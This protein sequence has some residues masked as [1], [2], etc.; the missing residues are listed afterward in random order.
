MQV[1][2]CVLVAILASLAS[3][4][5]AAI[6][7]VS[8]SWLDWQFADKNFHLSVDFDASKYN[9]ENLLEK[10]FEVESITFDF[11]RLGEF[12]KPFRLVGD[13][14][15][16]QFSVRYLPSRGELIELRGSFDKNVVEPNGVVAGAFSFYMLSSG[17]FGNTGH[18]AE[19]NVY[20]AFF[21][22]EDVIG[23]RAAYIQLPISA[24]MLTP[25]PESNIFTLLVGGLLIFRLKRKTWCKRIALTGETEG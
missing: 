1:A 19:L 5:N 15:T 16:S 11:A 4:A 21:S 14:T 2:R 17:V 10:I 8:G 24:G 3:V 9:E 18:G 13:V 12:G 25:V 6:L 7:D 23:L 20:E 22:F